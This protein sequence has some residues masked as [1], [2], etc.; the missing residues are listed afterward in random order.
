MRARKKH[1]LNSSG[2][3]LSEFLVVI[4]VIAI[5]SAIAIPAFSRWIP[6]YRLKGAARDLYSTMQSMK[7]TAIKNNQDTDF[8]FS[9]GTP[10]SHQY[11]SRIW[12][13]D[14]TVVLDSRTVVLADYGSGIRFQNHDST[15]TFTAA[16]SP[17]TFNGRGFTDA[18]GTSFFVYLSNQNNSDFYR[19]G[20][21]S[22][23]VISLQKWDGASYK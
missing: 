15:E 7:M 11:Q 9:G 4:A 14:K 17:I 6:Q 18:P 19:I 12:N 23:G 3:T 20:L 21:A 22:T 13:A 16:P 2:F 8:V 5:L 10:P 1:R